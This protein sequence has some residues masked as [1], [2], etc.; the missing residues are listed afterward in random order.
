MGF[1]SLF[2]LTIYV[3]AIKKTKINTYDISIRPYEDCCTVFV[4]EH[5]VIKPK[6][7]LII[8]D[9]YKCNLD[10]PIQTALENIKV[11]NVSKK[12][13]VNIFEENSDIFDI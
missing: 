1:H 5:P 7:D 9:E 2:F 6:L 8:E 12:E 11:Y 4:P 10:I 13:K 3:N